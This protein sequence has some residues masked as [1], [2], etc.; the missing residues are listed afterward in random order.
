MRHRNKDE[1]QA[2][3]LT[4]AEEYIL[5]L[6]REDGLQEAKI[7]LLHVALQNCLIRTR[8]RGCEESINSVR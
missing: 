7:S 6:V 4:I 1:G 2:R 5:Q 8:R 3:L